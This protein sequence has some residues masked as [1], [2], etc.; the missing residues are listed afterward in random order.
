MKIGMPYEGK[1]RDHLIKKREKMEKAFDFW[2][3]KRA[4]DEMYLRR[5]K[6]ES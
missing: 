5:K 3:E 4:R 6:I 1:T 2:G